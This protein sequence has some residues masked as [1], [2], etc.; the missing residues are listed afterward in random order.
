MR[1]RVKR[2]VQPSSLGGG[3]AYARPVGDR[4]GIDA[5]ASASTSSPAGGSQDLPARQR[6][7]AAA[8]LAARQRPPHQGGGAV[9]FRPNSTSADDDPV[10]PGEIGLV[11]ESLEKVSKPPRNLI[12][13]VERR[14][15]FQI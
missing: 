3:E 13:P 4:G 1:V 8:G 9:A 14:C 15:T 6:A 2:V 5:S 11:A 7:A 12:F 10:E